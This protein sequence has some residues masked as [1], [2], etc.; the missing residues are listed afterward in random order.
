MSG[1]SHRYL[2]AYD[3]IDDTRRSRLA[4]KLQSYGDRVQYSVFWIEIG[5]AR[6]VRLRAALE[7]IVDSGEDSVM[8]LDLGPASAP[9][10]ERVVYLGQQRSL[11]PTN[12]ILA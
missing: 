7:K 12:T 1:N 11:T 2:V 8:L 3:V 9:V 5:P 6:F 10:G 4:K